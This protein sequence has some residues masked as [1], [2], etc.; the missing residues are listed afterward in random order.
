[1]AIRAGCS[2]ARP[3][4]EPEEVQLLQLLYKGHLLLRVFVFCLHW[5]TDGTSV[6]V[7]CLVCILPG[8][9]FE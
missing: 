1:M 8:L 3:N 7:P 4:S 5:S 9:D 2:S 6:G